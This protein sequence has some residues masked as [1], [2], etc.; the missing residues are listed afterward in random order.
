MS[1]FDQVFENELF[2]NLFFLID[3]SFWICSETFDSTKGSILPQSAVHEINSV[4]REDEGYYICKAKNKLGMESEAAIEVRIDE[5]TDNELEPCR[6][7]TPCPPAG[8][9]RPAYERV[10][11]F[12]WFLIQHTINL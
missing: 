3:N 6:G 10:R 11:G 7:D 12:E 8:H 1:G 5:D 9:R 4:S 2:I